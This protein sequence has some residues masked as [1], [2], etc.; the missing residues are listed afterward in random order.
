MKYVYILST[1][2]EYGAEDVHATLDR[3]RIIPMIDGWFNWDQSPPPP[4]SPQG[5]YRAD[6]KNEAREKA[7]RLL[8]KNDETLAKGQKYELLSGWGGLQLHVVELT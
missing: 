3:N 2:D 5:L 6:Y 7:K 4:T 1:H 8:E